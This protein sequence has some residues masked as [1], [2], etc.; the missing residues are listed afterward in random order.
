MAI[1][2]IRA[3]VQKGNVTGNHFLV[4]AGEVT[5]GEVNFVGEL[6]DLAQKIG[7]RAETLDDSRYLRASGAGAPEIVSSGEVARGFGVFGDADLC[8]MLV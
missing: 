6:D 8:R 3:P 7:T 2:S 4:A 5:F 1:Q